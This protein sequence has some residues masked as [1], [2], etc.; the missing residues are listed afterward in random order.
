MRNPNVR[1]L[2]IVLVLIA[3]VAAA[4]AL[5]APLAAAALNHSISTPNRATAL[6]VYALIQNCVSAG[7][8]AIYG[9]AADVSLDT[10]FALCALAAACACCTF[11]YF[12]PRAAE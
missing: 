3:V 10:A 1:I 2:V 11:R 6:S 9:R 7:A 12:R 4:R 8:Q 5:I